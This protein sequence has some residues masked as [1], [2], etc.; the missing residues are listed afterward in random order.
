MDISTDEQK[1]LGLYPSDEQILAAREE[2]DAHAVQARLDRVEAA[3]REL[4]AAEAEVAAHTPE[5]PAEE[6]ATEEPQG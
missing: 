4:E 2:R 1:E 6:T 5:V 3:K